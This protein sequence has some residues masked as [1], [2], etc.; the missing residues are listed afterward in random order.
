[1]FFK[2]SEMDS[3]L[4]EI[5]DLLYSMDKKIDL[6]IDCSEAISLMRLSEYSL[7]DFLLDEPDIYTVDDVKSR[8]V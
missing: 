6:M 8:S 1:M 2:R 5:K 4:Q 3:D 7:K